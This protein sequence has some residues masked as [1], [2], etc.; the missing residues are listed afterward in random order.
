M[1]DPRPR[2]STD[3]RPE[4]S[5]EEIILIRGVQGHTWLSTY[6]P[7]TG[8]R[9]KLI[10]QLVGNARWTKHTKGRKVTWREVR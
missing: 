8:R 1:A 7:L 9:M 4:P 5:D 10:K 2:A 6:G 3:Q